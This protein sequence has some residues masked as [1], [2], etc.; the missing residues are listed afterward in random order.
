MLPLTE[1]RSCFEKQPELRLE[2]GYLP[3]SPLVLPLCCAYKNNGD[4]II[5]HTSL[6]YE[7]MGLA[8]I[9]VCQKVLTQKDHRV[10]HH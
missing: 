9:G 8:H 2:P 6:D 1:G 7:D 5:D 10:C 3:L 4:D